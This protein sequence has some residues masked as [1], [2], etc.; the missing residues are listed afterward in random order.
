MKTQIKIEKKIKFNFIIMDA[1]NYYYKYLHVYKNLFDL[2]ENWTG[3]YHGFFLKIQKIKKEH[4]GS[5]II[6]AWDRDPEIRKKI[7]VLYKANRKGKSKKDKE[8]IELRKM[9]SMYG[10]SQFYQ[11]GYEADDIIAKIVKDNLDKKILIMSSDKDLFQLLSDNVF[12][13]R[14]KFSKSSEKIHPTSPGSR[15]PKGSCW[16]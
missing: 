1:L 13:A 3:L 6:I 7:N 10:I 8:L 16:S 15:Y 4:S 9:L 2:K 11:N 5:K 14:K 12:I